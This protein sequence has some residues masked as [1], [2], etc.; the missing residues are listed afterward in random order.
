MVFP[1]TAPLFPV[2]ECY[3]RNFAAIHQFRIKCRTVFMDNCLLFESV[4]AWGGYGLTRGMFI[5]LTNKKRFGT[6]LPVSSHDFLE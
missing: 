5:F 4:R 2:F 1:Q 6:G 3:Q